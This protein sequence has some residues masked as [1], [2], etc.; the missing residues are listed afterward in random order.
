VGAAARKTRAVSE[1][2]TE[3][4]SESES[5]TIGAEESDSGLDGLDGHGVPKKKSGGGLDGLGPK[6]KKTGGAR[7]SG[8]GSG[9][10]F[11][12][13]ALQQRRGPGESR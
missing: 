7:E 8:S 3:S 10:G 4:E 1:P 12:G 9:S 11:R 6:K 2:A 13:L 5:E